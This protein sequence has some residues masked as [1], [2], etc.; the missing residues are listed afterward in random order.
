[1]AQCI[2]QSGHL[3]HRWFATWPFRHR[4]ERGMSDEERSG[5]RKNGEWRRPGR[6][7]C[8]ERSHRMEAVFVFWSMYLHASVAGRPTCT[9]PD[10]LESCS[11]DGFVCFLPECLRIGRVSTGM[12]VLISEIKVSPCLIKDHA[13]DERS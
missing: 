11:Q 1:M 5:S 9:L 13:T 12:F 6:R 4:R 2:Q 3:T 10:W 8:R 7:K